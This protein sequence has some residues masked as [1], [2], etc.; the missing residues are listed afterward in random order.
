MGVGGEG[1][2]LQIKACLVGVV[3]GGEGGTLLANRTRTVG[4]VLKYRA[5]IFAASKFNTKTFY[6]RLHPDNVDLTWAVRCRLLL[7]RDVK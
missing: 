4:P 6:I 3:P 5:A 2:L 1:T 7:L